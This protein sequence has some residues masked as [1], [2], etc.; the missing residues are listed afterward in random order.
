MPIREGEIDYGFMEEFIA[1]LNADRL[2][3]LNAY[4]SITGLKDYT[5]TP[6]EEQ[7]LH[8][9]QAGNIEWQEYKLGNLFDIQNTLSFNKEALVQ[10]S[11]YDYITRTSFNQGI[12]QTTGFVNKENLNEAGVWS[13]GLLQIDFFYRNR[14]WYAGQFMRKIISK[15]DLPQR[16]ILFFTTLLNRLKPV[17]LSVLVRDVDKTFLNS[18]ILL[19]NTNGEIDYGYM[20]TLIS[21][22]QKL[23][24]KEVVQYAD[25][26]IAATRQVIDESPLRANIPSK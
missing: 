20:E 10:G 12:L 1:K 5:L 19:P 24:I 2:A 18:T 11:E 22:V 14:E 7:A 23:V 13:L 17:L 16:S 26:E 9:F 15:V 3:K 25:R 21:A 4:R 6:Q 8:R